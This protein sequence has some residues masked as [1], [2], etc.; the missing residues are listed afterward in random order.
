MQDTFEIK[1]SEIPPN[2]QD[3]LLLDSL[4]L[5]ADMKDFTIRYD[6]TTSRKT[7]TASYLNYETYSKFLEYETVLIG[8]AMIKVT[9]LPYQKTNPIS[10][11]PSVGESAHTNPGS[12]SSNDGF[13]GPQHQHSNESTQNQETQENPSQ[14]RQLIT[15]SLAL[16][17]VD[18]DKWNEESLGYE[19]ERFGTIENIFRVSYSEASNLSSFVIVYNDAPGASNAYEQTEDEDYE[20]SIEYFDCN[21]QYEI[22]HDLN[23]SQPMEI[24][25]E[26]FYEDD[27][28]FFNRSLIDEHFNVEIDSVADTVDSFKTEP[29]QE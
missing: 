19:F 27:E 14:I 12:I 2:T 28:L 6:Q 17:N 20:F 13:F 8:G 18:S 29:E 3:S 23:L 4:N 1:F 15:R 22:D 16:F 26:D 7:L 5:I 11:Q 24:D 21:P 25:E 9:P 10:S